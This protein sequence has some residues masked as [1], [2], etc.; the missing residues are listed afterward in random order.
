MQQIHGITYASRHF[1]NRKNDTHMQAINSNWFNTFKC[2][3]E[4]D[5]SEEF[6]TKYHQVWSMGERGGG[7]WIW[8]PYIIRNRLQTMNDDEI[9]VYYDSGCDL[10]ITIDSTI[11][12]KEYID[13]VNKDTNGFLRFEL[14]G[15]LEKDWTNKATIEFFKQKF[16]I[17][18]DRL[19]TFFNSSQL[20]GTVLIMRK[21]KFVIDFFDKCL[22]ILNDDPNLFTDIY[23]NFNETHRHDQSIISLLYKQ[24]NFDLIIT[25]ET[26]FDD[27]LFN[28]DNAKKY[29]IWATR[30]RT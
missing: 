29:P 27:G 8:K 5:I 10:N 9:L 3:D 15:L 28:S 16:N 25:D 19:E 23:T 1:I 13:L 14:T 21:N 6:K 2:F 11:R 20:V 18:E 12:F 22:E 30:K 4:T 26:Y 17:D 7:Y 24:L